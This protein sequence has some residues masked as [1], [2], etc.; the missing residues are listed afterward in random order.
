MVCLSVE[1][2]YVAAHILS[3]YTSRSY[4]TFVRE[5]LLAPLNMTRTTFS[6]DEAMKTGN[7]SQ[8][9]IDPGRRR[10]PIWVTA[11]SERLVAGS[12]GIISCAADMV[13][14]VD[15]DRNAVAFLYPLIVFRLIF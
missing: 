7:L 6:T 3:K 9:W 1:L 2:Y 8:A 10:I 12:R 5:R 15:V 14:R 11:E 13:S 4:A